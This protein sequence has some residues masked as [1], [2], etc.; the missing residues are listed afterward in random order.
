MTNSQAAAKLESLPTGN[1][2]ICLQ[3][4]VQLSDD[5]ILQEVIRLNLNLD[6]FPTRGALV[7]HIQSQQAGCMSYELTE[8]QIAQIWAILQGN[9]IE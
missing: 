4:P 7:A 6:N 8:S 1:S 9:P 2:V 3:G 5:S